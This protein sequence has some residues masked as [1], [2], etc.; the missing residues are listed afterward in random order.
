M[1]YR[2]YTEED[3]Q[4]YQLAVGDIWVPLGA[5]AQQR[6]GDVIYRYY[7]TKGQQRFAKY[8]N[9]NPRTSAQMNW[10]A[11]YANGVAAWNA[12]AEPDKATWRQEAVGKGTTGYNLF[13]CDYLDTHTIATDVAIVGTATVGHYVVG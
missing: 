9:V 11:V 7:A 5:V 12:L 2:S 13:M 6:L 4:C 3:K 8:P 10:R 1:P